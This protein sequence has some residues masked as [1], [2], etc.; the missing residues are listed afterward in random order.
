[1][2]REKSKIHPSQDCGEC[3]SPSLLNIY[4]R[5]KKTGHL[6]PK[7]SRFFVPPQKLT[8]NRYVTVFDGSVPPLN[9]RSMNVTLHSRSMRTSVEERVP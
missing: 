8:L 7:V 9:V 3:N 1:M 6:Y 2:N 5:K 4:E